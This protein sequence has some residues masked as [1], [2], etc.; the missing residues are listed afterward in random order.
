MEYGRWYKGIRKGKTHTFLVGKLLNADYATGQKLC[1]VWQMATSIIHG[2]T[3]VFNILAC[4]LWTPVR[5]YRHKMTSECDTLVGRR[6]L[7][8]YIQ[9]FLAHLGSCQIWSTQLSFSTQWGYI[10]PFYVLVVFD[11]LYKILPCSTLV[12]TLWWLLLYLILLFSANWLCRRSSC[13]DGQHDIR[14]GCAE[15]PM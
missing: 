7:N 5:T 8:V 11:N 6:F 13:W 1:S 10:P 4:V 9:L 15:L 3:R 14:W 2:H 12:L